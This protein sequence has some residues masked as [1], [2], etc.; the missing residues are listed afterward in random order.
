MTASAAYIAAYEAHNEALRIYDIARNKF[1]AIPGI[2]TDGDALEFAAAQAAKR[3][4]DALFDAAYAAE[5]GA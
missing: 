2:A 4:A 1:R 3:E 5:Q